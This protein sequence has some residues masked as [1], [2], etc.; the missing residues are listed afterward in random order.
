MDSKGTGHTW[1]QNAPTQR[2][3]SIFLNNNE[4]QMDQLIV[5]LCD[6]TDRVHGFCTR[7]RN[8]M[9]T[10]LELF[11]VYWFNFSMFAH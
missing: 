2:V 8:R 11:F 4:N 5:W 1:R 3:R 10:G 6:H 9:E 7:E